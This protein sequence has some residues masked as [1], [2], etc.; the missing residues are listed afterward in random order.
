MNIYSKFFSVL[1]NHLD[2]VKLRKENK[3]RAIK[4]QEL[5]DQSKSDINRWKSKEEF[6]ENWNER[7]AILASMIPEHS[8]IIEFG[9]GNLELRKLL[10]KGCSYTPT[11]I[12][13]RYPGMLVCDLNE[14]I[15]INLKDYDTAVFSGV[16]EYVYDIEGVIRELEGEINDI[17]LSY[18]CSDISH[19]PR[20]ERGWL[21]DFTKADLEVIFLKNGFRVIEYQEWRKQSIFH[22]EAEKKKR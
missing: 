21:S 1:R 6:H 13:E 9:A 19:A 12:C 7:T 2:E 3:T 8:K 10:P 20:L 11:D 18:A 15:N 16:L 4:T 22:L 14:S 17:I 5:R